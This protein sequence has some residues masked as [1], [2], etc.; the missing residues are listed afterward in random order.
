MEWSGSFRGGGFR[1]W[2]D[3]VV[4]LS[5]VVCVDPSLYLGAFSSGELTADTTGVFGSI[6]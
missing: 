6:G 5:A 2:T 1:G 3:F 4:D